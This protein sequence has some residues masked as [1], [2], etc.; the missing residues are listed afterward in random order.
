MSMPPRSRSRV[1][2]S[3]EVRVQ[4][5]C[6]TEDDLCTF[7]PFTVTSPLRTASDLLVDPIQFGITE[8]VALRL[9]FPLI[10]GGADT[11]RAQTLATRRPHRRLALNRLTQLAGPGV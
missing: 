11:V 3:A 2:G 10:D 8:H 5:L 9:L 6:L 1:L 4:E 7:G